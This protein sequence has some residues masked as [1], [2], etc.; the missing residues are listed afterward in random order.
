MKLTKVQFFLLCLVSLLFGATIVPRL[1]PTPTLTSI[2]KDNLPENGELVV[3]QWIACPIGYDPTL[4]HVYPIG[5]FRQ[6]W[7]DQR[8]DYL[9][10]EPHGPEIGFTGKQVTFI[11]PTSNADTP[12]LGIYWL[13]DDH[14][15]GVKAYDR[16]PLFYTDDKDITACLGE[17]TQVICISVY[18]QDYFYLP[19]SIATYARVWVGWID[20]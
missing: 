12:I 10:S 20:R 19:D 13:K 11:Y 15:F 14:L 2:C 9:I 1:L 5:S 3:Y 18:Q 17:E 4:D 6:G 16:D 8:Y 7:I